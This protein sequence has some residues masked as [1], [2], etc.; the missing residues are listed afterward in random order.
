LYSGNDLVFIGPYLF[1]KWDIDPAIHREETPSRV[2]TIQ[3]KMELFSS[4]LF[5]KS[6]FGKIRRLLEDSSRGIKFH[7]E[8]FEKATE[9]M[10]GLTEERGFS[11]IIEFFQLLQL[12]SNS[13]ETTYLA[14]AGFAP[15]GIPA[16]G[17][18]IQIAYHYILKNYDKPI[19]I[20]AVASLLNMSTSAFSHFFKKYTNKSFRQFLVDVRLGHACKLLLDT[21][22]NIKQICYRSGF[23]NVANFNRLFK[24]YRSCT[25]Y[26]F[27]LRSLAK[28]SFDW[29]SQ[30]TPG[31]FI[32]SGKD[33]K[34]SFQPTS[35]STTRVIHY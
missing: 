25:P 24:K 10:I 28:D 7:G 32:P 21:D 31:Q 23:N 19:K 2:I 22:Q 5:Q 4:Q 14:S 27:R 16:K 18:R 29:T 15:K 35:Y 13:T 1:H 17:K 9:M 8:T 34:E 3:F 12:L 26:E 30:L 6:G 11:N 33:V 20:E